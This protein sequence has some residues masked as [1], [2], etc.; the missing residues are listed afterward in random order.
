VDGRGGGEKKVVLGLRLRRNVT[1]TFV[2][3]GTTRARLLYMSQL[4]KS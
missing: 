1:L 2:I 3:V 4:A